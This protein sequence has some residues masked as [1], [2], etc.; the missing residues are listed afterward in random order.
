M[1]TETNRD[2]EQVIAESVLTPKSRMRRWVSTTITEMKRFLGLIFTMGLVKKVRIEEYWCTDLT[3][4]PIFNS[5]MPRDRFELL[6][7]FWHFSNNDFAVDGDRLSKLRG[8]CNALIER[9]QALYT[10]GKEVS[11]DE[12]MVL[13]RGR[14]I[15]RQ[16]IPGK[17]HKYGVKLY[18]LCEHTG[19]VWNVLVYCGKMDPISG[20]GHAETVVLKLMEKRLDLGHVLFV[21]NFYTSVPLAEALLNRKTLL[22]GTLR[23]NRKHLP[24]KVVS[25]K[26]KKGQH[27]AKRKG[28]I[29]VE[30][31]QDKREVLMLST[32]H[33]GKMVDSQKQTRQGERKRKPESIVSYNKFMCGVDRMDQMMSYYSPLRKTLKWYRKVVL[34]HFDMAIVNAFILYRKVGG[35]KP[36]LGFRKSVIDSLLS[37]DVRTSEELPRIS[38]KSFHHHKTS[39]LSRLSGQHYL[40]YIPATSSKRNCTRKCV[41]CNR[42]GRRK[43]TRYMCE[44]CNSKPA[45]CVVPCFKIFHEEVCI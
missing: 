27:I 3:A 29:V 30:K 14:L 44:T 10:P 38:T 39:D 21:D 11:I 36:Q 6:L 12:S 40:G 34:Q 20:F 24:K 33:S 5:T 23:K 28:R 22:C 41:V 35:T 45:L 32:Y 8:I 7:R 43:E 13:W 42:Q 18:M 19:Y 16:Y 2:A 1:V 37:A 25:T 26:L 4:T 31:W 9:F 17:R 15:F